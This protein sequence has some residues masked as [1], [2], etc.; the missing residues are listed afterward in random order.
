MTTRAMEPY[1]SPPGSVPASDSSSPPVLDSRRRRILFRATHRGTHETD[2]LI[3]GFVSPRI[4]G[5]D[6]AELDAL[7]ELMELP[8]V[9]LADWLM[10]RLPIPPECDTPML[11]AVEAA[12]RSRSLA[13]LKR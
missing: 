9:D 4:A 12:A 3:G 6:D 11:R 5:F 10:G 7:E 2:V 8:D 1:A 13:G